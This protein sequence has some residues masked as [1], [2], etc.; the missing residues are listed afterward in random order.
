M[1]QQRT[2]K[3]YSHLNRARPPTDLGP[4]SRLQAPIILFAWRPQGDDTL[5][6]TPTGLRLYTF[7]GFFPF[8]F[9][10]KVTWPDVA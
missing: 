2:S 7:D 9:P 4:A 10:G 8:V 1:Q 6:L 5:W 3:A